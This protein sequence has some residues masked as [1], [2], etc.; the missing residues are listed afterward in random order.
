M[1]AIRKGV[2]D[3]R[4]YNAIFMPPLYPHTPH[5]QTNLPWN[6]NISYIIMSFINEKSQSFLYTFH[7]LK[8]ILISNI[9]TGF[10]MPDFSCTCAASPWCKIWRYYNTYK[11]CF[12]L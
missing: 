9:K 12:A 11:I 10:A 1:N 2:A 8:S 6:K 7:F 5:P 3:G 4:T